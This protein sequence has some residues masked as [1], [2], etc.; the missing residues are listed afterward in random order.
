MR[1]MIDAM[2]A[3]VRV[4]PSLKPLVAV[5]GGGAVIAVAYLARLA[6]YCPDIA[7]RRDVN[8]EPWQG[9]VSLVGG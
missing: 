4:S 2:R 7:W 3:H 6:L 5:V 9:L 8:P 1:R